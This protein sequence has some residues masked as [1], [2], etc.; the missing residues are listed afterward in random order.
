[1]LTRH[2]FKLL[3]ISAFFT[4]FATAGAQ[5]SVK[6]I[7][8]DY[9]TIEVQATDDLAKI[10]ALSTRKSL[11]VLLAFTSSTCGYCEIL[12]NSVLKPMLISGDYDH[13]VIIRKVVIDEV[14]DVVDFD[15]KTIPI[16]EFTGR[17]KV[18]VT[19]TVLFLDHQGRELSKRMIGI[20][21]VDYY[22]A[23]MDNA[24]DRSVKKFQ[25]RLQKQPGQ[26]TSTSR[27]EQR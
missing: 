9:R 13:K 6:N 18:F 24:I 26:L 15:G 19:P 12:Q 10:A 17:Y 7:S 22:T 2:F 1:M 8:A 4:W 5:P 25:Q 27:R 11:P 20:N 16:S 14:L 23:D 3:L 21:T